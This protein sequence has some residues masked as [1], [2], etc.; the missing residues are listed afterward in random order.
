MNQH[1]L[2]SPITHQKATDGYRKNKTTQRHHRREITSSK[3]KSIKIE[4]HQNHLKFIKILLPLQLLKDISPSLKAS[5]GSHGVPWGAL[6][7]L[8]AAT[9]PQEAPGARAPGLERPA[10]P[11]RTPGPRAA[12]A[13]DAPRPA[14]AGGAK[15]NRRHRYRRRGATRAPECP[16]RKECL[17]DIY[18][19]SYIF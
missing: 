11:R 17:R 8:G 1:Y 12:A 7:S 4:I 16:A 14:T 9:C 13:A 3:S 2:A 6:G 19:F 5:M 10:V 15:G 18:T